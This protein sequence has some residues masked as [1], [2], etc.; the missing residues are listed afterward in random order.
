MLF[1]SIR[2]G[3]IKTGK[4]KTGKIKTGKTRIGKIRASIKLTNLRDTVTKVKI[5]KPIRQKH[6]LFRIQTSL[7][8]I[9]IGI[10]IKPIK[11]MYLKSLLSSREFLKKINRQAQPI[12]HRR[13]KKK[14][15]LRKKY[16]LLNWRKRNFLL[17][18]LEK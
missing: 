2:I 6:K 9:S 18:K 11:N 3:K 13:Q 10:S 4:I 17:K 16:N 1:R 15:L 12:L 14:K 8:K 5:C 7:T